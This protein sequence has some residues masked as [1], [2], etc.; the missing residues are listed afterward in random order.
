MSEQNT[1]EVDS[2]R[3][4]RFLA[5]DMNAAERAQTLADLADLP[6]EQLDVFAD[7]AAVLRERERNHPQLPFRSRVP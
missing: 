2:L 3:L 6:C 5:G 7:A 1:R 4:A